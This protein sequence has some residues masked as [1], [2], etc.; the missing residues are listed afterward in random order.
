MLSSIY[1]IYIFLAVTWAHTPLKRTDVAKPKA[2]GIYYRLPTSV[3]PNEYLVIL[4]PNFTNFT[5]EGYVEIDITV[6]E[7][8]TNITLH[9]AEITFIETT[10]FN[11]SVSVDIANEEDDATREF[12]ILEFN[13]SLEPGDYTIKINY[14]GILNDNL[15]GF[16]KSYYTDADGATR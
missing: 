4:E 12:R 8:T 14:T 5:F 10:V 15:R 7:S 11:G 1:V 13:G 3:E 16:Y 2:D 9:A 6:L